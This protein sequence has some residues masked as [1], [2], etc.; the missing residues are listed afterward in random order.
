MA[1][2]HVHVSENALLRNVSNK[3]ILNNQQLILKLLAN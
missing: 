1:A 3:A 2:S